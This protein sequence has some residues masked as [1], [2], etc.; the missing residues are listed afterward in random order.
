VDGVAHWPETAATD[1]DGFFDT[2][3]PDCEDGVE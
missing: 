2:L 3:N 1:E